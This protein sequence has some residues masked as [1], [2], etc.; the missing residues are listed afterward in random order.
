M[1]KKIGLQSNHGKKMMIMALLIALVV[2]AT[3]C[4]EMPEN[5]E[6]P[7]V[8]E[9]PSLPKVNPNILFANSGRTISDTGKIISTPTTFK[10]TDL[11]VE[12]PEVDPGEKFLILAHLANTGNS[13]GSYEMKLEVNGSVK[14]TKEVYLAAGEV[15]ELQVSGNEYTPGGCSG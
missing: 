6:V 7:A 3:S 2:F 12:P 11:I 14:F 15:V 8:S 5:P 1:N 13:A 10:F 4:N 9:P